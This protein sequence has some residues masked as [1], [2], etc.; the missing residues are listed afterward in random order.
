[1]APE[2]SVEMRMETCVHQ[3]VGASGLRMLLALEFFLELL[4]MYCPLV[5]MPLPQ[6]PFPPRT[7]STVFLKTL[8]QSKARV[9]V[10]V[11]PS[12]PCSPGSEG[13]TVAKD[14]F[15]EGDRTRP[16][17]PGESLQGAQEEHHTDV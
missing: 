4:A 8:S 9:A 16:T 11:A 10:S 1:M 2:H 12:C 15:R 6:L 17:Y 3:E 13:N 5:L 7:P 14:T